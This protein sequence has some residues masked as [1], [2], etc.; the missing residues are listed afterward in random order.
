MDDAG[1]RRIIHVLDGIV[2]SVH[3]NKAV[4]MKLKLFFFVVTD[5]ISDMD[6]HFLSF[7]SVQFLILMVDRVDVKW[8][9]RR[10]KFR[11]HSVEESFCLRYL[12]LCMRFY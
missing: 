8:G 12:C 3:Q 6:D 5:D 10:V 9:L 1:V 4:Q 2:C 7:H 11:F